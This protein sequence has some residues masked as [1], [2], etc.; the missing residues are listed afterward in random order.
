MADGTGFG[1]TRADYPN[2]A[3]W[4]GSSSVPL[5]VGSCPADGRFTA[6][7]RRDLSGPRGA[8]RPRLSTNEQ[9][10]RF[11]ASSWISSRGLSI[12]IGF[13]SLGGSERFLRERFSITFIDFN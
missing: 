1:W 5:A 12:S 4:A 7:H 10:T 3:G 6:C 8:W 13:I 9:F 11:D 2:G